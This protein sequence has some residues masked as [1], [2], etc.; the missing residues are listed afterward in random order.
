MS[1]KSINKQY[2]VWANE[3]THEGEALLY[4][5]PSI[6]AQ[7]GFLF[8]Q[9]LAVPAHLP[10]IEFN[11]DE[12]SQGIMTDNL[13]AAGFKGLLF[14]TRL[15]KLLRFNGIHNFQE[16]PV[17]LHNRLNDT[18]SREYA[19]VNIIGLI[20]CLDV[21]NSRF[22]RSPTGDCPIEFIYKLVLNTSLIKNKEFFRLCEIPQ[23]LIVNNKIKV[24]CESAQITG[25]RFYAPEQYLF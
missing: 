19:L 14:S 23:I 24:A 4:G 18:E 13:I 8:N 25:V 10:L 9:G 5:S 15:R 12:N 21:E 17:L 6:I 20:S 11:Q 16:F 2:W 7:C 3:P 1:T 22:K